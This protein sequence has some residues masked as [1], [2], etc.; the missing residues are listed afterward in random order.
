MITNYSRILGGFEMEFV[1]RIGLDRAGGKK[2]E[3]YPQSHF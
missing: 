2:F 1:V 3:R